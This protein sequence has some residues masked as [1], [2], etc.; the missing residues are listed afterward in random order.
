MSRKSEGCDYESCKYSV[1]GCGKCR[2]RDSHVFGICHGPFFIFINRLFKSFKRIECLPESLNNRNAS[3][4]FNSFTRHITQCIL[5]FLHII[6]HLRSHHKRTHKN[7]CDYRRNKAY[8]PQSPVK[9]C[10]HAYKTYRCCNG[11]DFIR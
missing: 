3:Y 9:K 8:K 10:Q 6:C 11:Y 7:E 5:V 4:I 1:G 2:H